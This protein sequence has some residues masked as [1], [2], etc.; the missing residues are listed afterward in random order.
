MNRL[1]WWIIRA[2]AII[3]FSLGA[4]FIVA[5]LLDVEKGLLIPGIVMAAV[6]LVVGVF[7]GKKKDKA[8][9]DKVRKALKTCKKCGGT[10]SSKYE[11]TYKLGAATKSPYSGLLVVP[12]TISFK[13]TQCGKEKILAETF[14]I[15]GVRPEE[16]IKEVVADKVHEYL[17]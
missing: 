15:A 17:G 2:V 13:C 14:E 5:D 4:F 3:V 16:E 1:F 7:A 9:G 8:R 10:Y 12:G 6:G 11:Y